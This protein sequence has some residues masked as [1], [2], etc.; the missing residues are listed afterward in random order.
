MNRQIK[1]RCWD[2]DNKTMSNVNTLLLSTN[3]LDHEGN[4]GEPKSIDHFKLMQFTGQLD[5]DGEE[6]Y[7]GD[8]VSWY[9]EDQEEMLGVI[10]FEQQAGQFWVKQKKGKTNLYSPMRA[11]FSDG[12]TYSNNSLEVLGN[13][14]EDEYL[15]IKR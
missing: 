7:E 15:L 3:E 8:V 9:K 2:K 1:F 10:E 11:S 4:L 13:I 14:Y 6:I 5:K 12:K